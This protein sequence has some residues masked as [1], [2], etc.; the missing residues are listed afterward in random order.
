MRCLTILLFFHLHFIQNGS[1]SLAKT[2]SGC[3]IPE[4]FEFEVGTFCLHAISSRSLR[5]S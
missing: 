1:E 2:F 4:K 3:H 5:F